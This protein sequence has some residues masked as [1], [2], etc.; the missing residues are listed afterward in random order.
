MNKV[1]LSPQGPK[2]S[3]IIAG[4]WKW[5]VWGHKLDAAQQRNLIHA[6]MDQGVTTF[7]HADIYGNHQGE[8]EF[9]EAI[10]GAS[11]IRSEIQLITKCGIKMPSD[12]FDYASKSYDT[13]PE[14]IVMSVE[15]SLRNF[16]TD[17]LDVLLIHR[18]SPLMDPDEIAETMLSL[19]KQGKVLHAG[20]SNFTTSQFSLLASRMP[21]VNNQ[22]QA[23]LLHRDPF[24]DGT[25]DQQLQSRI[26]PTIWSPLGSGALFTA[27]KSTGIAKI[28]QT[29]RDIIGSYD[30]IER[31]DQL[32]LAWLMR[33]PSK[34]I[35]VLGTARPERVEAAV[36]ACQI[37]MSREDWFNLWTAA[38]G[39]DV[40]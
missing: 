40:P 39:T 31:L 20:V 7:D 15:N 32:Y 28:A 17:Y 9:G 26:R 16:K 29:A 12:K 11:S 36:K 5:G 3:P 8:Q 19:Q 14:H 21:L 25:L 2:V 27:T 18:P 1:S 22:V 24:L 38:T 4:V 34:P 23:S 6:C 13:S 30:G 37:S 35:P 33:H 10:G